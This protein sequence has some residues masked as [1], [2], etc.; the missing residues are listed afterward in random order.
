MLKCSVCGDEMMEWMLFS[1]QTSFP[2][3]SLIVETAAVHSY[4]THT[5]RER[6]RVREGR[7][8]GEKGGDYIPLSI[9]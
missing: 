3:S 5:E 7:R 4:K 9:Q 6:E 2:V 8:E 1:W